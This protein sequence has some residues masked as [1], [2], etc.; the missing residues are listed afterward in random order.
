LFVGTGFKAQCACGFAGE[1]SVGS[2]RAMHGK[3]FWYP[4]MCSQ[5]HDVVSPDMMADSLAC[6]ECGSAEITSYAAKSKRCKEPLAR[7]LPPSWRKTLGMH[8]VDD[9]AGDTWCYP[10]DKP[11]YLMKSGNTCPA[12]RQNNMRFSLSV[13][14]D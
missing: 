10:L 9:E 12:C 14:F 4:Y 3:R 1:A 2:T 11:L 13:Q 8:H 7:W 6:P 5:C